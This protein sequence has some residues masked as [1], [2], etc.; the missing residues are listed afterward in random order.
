MFVVIELVYDL[1]QKF[2]LEHLRLENRSKSQIGPKIR[3]LTKL[4]L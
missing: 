4:K 2:M 1:V 3:I